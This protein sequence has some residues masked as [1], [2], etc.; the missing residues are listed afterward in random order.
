VNLVFA[1]AKGQWEKAYKAEYGH[2]ARAATAAV[3]DGASDLKTRGR[4]I[5][6]A[7][8]L[9]RRFQNAFR[10]EVY[11]RSGSSVDA[12]MFAHHNIP[13][14]GVFQTGEGI[15]GR[16]LMWVPLPGVPHRIGPRHMTP[17][18][19]QQLVGPLHFD[20]RPG[21]KPI[22]AAYARGVRQPKRVTM[23]SLK[24]GSALARLG[25]REKRG[26]HGTPG[27]VSVPVFVGV[28]SVKMPR[29][30]DLR[31]VFQRA[32]QALGPAYQRHFRSG[33]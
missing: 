2:V 23:A 15:A 7:S 24:A 6:G 9:G 12:A 5:I 10:V 19:Y 3:R 33:V 11:P 22:L 21:H 8:G 29:R 14:A 26:R 32:S 28:S 16:P 17:R 4:A 18:N 13:Y 31:P 27:V 30:F 25:V 1:A 20:E